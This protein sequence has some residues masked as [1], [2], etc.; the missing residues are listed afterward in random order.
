MRHCLAL[1]VAA[2][3]ACLGVTAGPWAA[4][5]SPLTFHAGFEDTREAAG[6]PGRVAPVTVAGT[7]ACVPGKVGKAPVV[8]G[9]AAQLQ[10]PVAG[11]VRPTQG[12][13]ARIPT[14]LST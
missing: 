9:D 14:S 10:Y 5:L 4:P 13:V 2:I 1:P 6:T 7:V 3:A 8:G 12:T 11:L